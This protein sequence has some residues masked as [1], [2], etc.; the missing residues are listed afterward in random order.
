MGQLLSKRPKVLKRTRDDSA[1]L[2]KPIGKCC[3][4]GT[5]HRGDARGSWEVISGV[6]TY[7]SKPPEGRA[8]GHVLLYFP[9]AWGLFPN[10]LLVMDAF[11]DAGFL[12]LGLDYFRGVRLF[13]T[14][15]GRF[16]CCFCF[17][18]STGSYL[19]ASPRSSRCREQ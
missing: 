12:T 6:E 11:A 17:L 2:A 9:D 10:A 18:I 16:F 1:Y 4:E 19:E 8:N 3:R 5:I 15:S 14:G 13:T 7:I